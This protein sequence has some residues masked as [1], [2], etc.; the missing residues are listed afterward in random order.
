M[1]GTDKHLLNNNMFPKMKSDIEDLATKINT[2]FKRKIVNI[3]FEGASKAQRCALW[4][5]ADLLFI[6][7]FKDGLCLVIN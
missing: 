2:T 7:C 6:T 3:S 5:R 4:S 1:K